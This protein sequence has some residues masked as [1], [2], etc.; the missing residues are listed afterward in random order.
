MPH[1]FNLCCA[2]IPQP[3][4]LGTFMNGVVFDR[5]NDPVTPDQWI[6][7]IEVLGF[8]QIL[9]KPTGGR[10][11]KG[12][13]FFEKIKDRYTNPDGY[14]FSAAF[15]ESIISENDFLVQEGIVQHPEIA[16]IY[17]DS[18]IHSEW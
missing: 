1:R 2:Y 11:G 4:V 13:Y 15:I 6:T 14:P 12:I 8:D 9:I 18:V 17:P 10:G 7:D 16:N 5:H 3:E